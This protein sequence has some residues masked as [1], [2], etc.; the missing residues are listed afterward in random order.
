MSVVIAVDPATKSHESASLIAF[1]VAGRGWPV[2]S[3]YGDDRPR[4]YVMDCEQGRHTPM[5]AMQR[6]A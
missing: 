6:A 3:L 2:E 5:Q 1:T 4:G